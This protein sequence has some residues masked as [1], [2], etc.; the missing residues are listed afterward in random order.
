MKRLLSL[1]LVLLPWTLASS[2]QE[3]VPPADVEAAELGETPNVHRSGELWF[4]GQFAPADVEALKARG[5]GR[6]ISARTAGELKWDEKALVEAAGMEF[7]T[8]PFRA[9]ETLTD[10]LF[11]QVRALLAKDAAPTLLHCG[12]ANRVGGAWLPYRVL[13]QGV[14]LERALAEAKQIGLRTVAYQ[15]RAVA[16]IERQRAE[17]VGR[18]ESIKEGI[19]DSFKDPELDVS[20][21]VARFEIEAREVYAARHDIVKA[22]GVGPGMRV[23]DV[24]AGTGLYTFLFSEAVGP[25][26]WVF[27]VDIAPRFLERIRGLAG[28]RGV[29]NVSGVLC[30]ENSIGLPP[31]SVDLAFVCDTYHHFEYPLSTTRSIHRALKPGARLIV[32]DFERI[33]E[34]S[35]EWILGHVRAGK[36]DFRAEIEEAG[37]EFVGQIALPGLEENYLLEFR[38]PAR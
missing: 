37:F 2:S 20:G 30:P 21:F 23:A 34:T 7:L 5:I 16:Y 1:F 19:N 17:G 11:D 33:P 22:I 8:V 36:A 28:D 27:A 9:P 14:P 6:V 18:E 31:A 12:S 3:P 24:G 10:E 13:D 25:D 38:K 29:G 35:R 32:I 4:A 26:G 15:E